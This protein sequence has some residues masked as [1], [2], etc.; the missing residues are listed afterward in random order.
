[1]IE[2]NDMSMRIPNKLHRPR[3]TILYKVGDKEEWRYK[4]R[5]HDDIQPYIKIVGR[6]SQ[7]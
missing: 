6:C 4:M 3:A 2:F 7:Q 5:F 1:M